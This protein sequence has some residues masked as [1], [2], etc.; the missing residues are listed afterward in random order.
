MVNYENGKIYKIEA[1]NAPPDEKVYVGSTTK[2]YLS[3]RMDAHRSQYKIFKSGVKI[4]KTTSFD[5]F[6]KYG[7]E[8][9]S[10]V[11]LEAVNC[12]SKD[13]LL[14]REKFYFKSLNCINRNTP[15]MDKE[16]ILLRQKKY[17]IKN[18]EKFKTYKEENKEK[19]RDFNI[20]YKEN[21]KE[22]LKLSNKVYYLNQKINILEKR[23]VKTV[24]S[25]GA[26]FCLYSK[27]RH[28]K[29]KKHIEYINSLVEKV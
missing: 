9:C 4:N 27:C 1:M 3:Q 11:L 25:C 12:K 29:T 16:D 8:N 23:K 6:D 24:C 26:T 18:I 5:L 10:I 19:I 2:K 17:Y 13:D 15:I 22:D 28:E 21:N 20:K 7:V 14:A